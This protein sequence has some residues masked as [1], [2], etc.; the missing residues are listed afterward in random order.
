VQAAWPGRGRRSGTSL[1][2]R[3]EGAPLDPQSIVDAPHARRALCRAEHGATL[4]PG[5]NASGQ[6]D[7]I[8]LHVDRDAVGFTRHVPLERLL[9]RLVQCTLGD[10]GPFDRDLV[11]HVADAWGLAHHPLRLVALP[12]RLQATGQVTTP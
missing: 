7:G 12:E 2:R 6:H 8:A 3:L 1:T 9:D 10:R 4:P 11:R 5:C